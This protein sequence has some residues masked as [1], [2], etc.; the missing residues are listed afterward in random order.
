[1]PYKS[2]E[3]YNEY[4]RAYKQKRWIDISL[5]LDS[6]RLN[7]EFHVF[8]SE[9]PFNVYAMEPHGVETFLKAAPTMGLDSK[10]MRHYH[11]RLVKSNNS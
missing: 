10:K 1:M 9:K 2:R 6:F 7:N 3:K 4:M 11:V 8:V 5:L